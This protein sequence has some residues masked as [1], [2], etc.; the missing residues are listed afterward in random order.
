MKVRSRALLLFGIFLGIAVTA[1][2]IKSIIP[3]EEIESYVRD[4]NQCL[5]MD[6]LDGAITA[7][8]K[9]IEGMAQ[10]KPKKDYAL[11]YYKRGRA[12]ER[13]EYLSEAL[14]DYRKSTE[15]NPMFLLGYYGSAEI[16]LER[17]DFAGA[18]A[19]YQ[20]ILEIDSNQ[21]HACNNIGLVYVRQNDY[22]HAIPWFTKAITIDP[23]FINAH[24]NRAVAYLNQKNY[25]EAI[26]DL[27][28]EVELLPTSFVAKN[29]R[30]AVRHFFNKR[31]HEA[32]QSVK[33]LMKTKEQISPVFIEEL[34]AA[35]GFDGLKPEE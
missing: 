32:W 34:K 3:E 21:P 29:Y 24:H 1:F 8:S 6:D 17:R 13:K 15:Y 30:L 20:K 4:G 26:L 19:D 5:T 18:L 7:F 14:S 9:A 23:D 35:S 16:L 25:F 33:M 11:A 12:Y 2:P 22:E 27:D 31:Y 28:K 10:S